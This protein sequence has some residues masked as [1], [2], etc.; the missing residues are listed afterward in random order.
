MH[1]ST[2]LNQQSIGVDQQHDEYRRLSAQL[3]VRATAHPY[4]TAVY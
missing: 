2:M 1:T 3:P 4:P